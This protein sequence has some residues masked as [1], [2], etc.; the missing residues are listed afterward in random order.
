MRGGVSSAD[1]RK[2][3]GPPKNCLCAVAW[4]SKHGLRAVLSRQ[5]RGRRQ[6]VC[7]PGARGEGS[8]VAAPTSPE[9]C[10]GSAGAEGHPRR[11]VQCTGLAEDTRAPA[12]QSCA[13]SFKT[14]RSRAA[15]QGSRSSPRHTS[16]PSPRVQGDSS[17]QASS[18]AAPVPLIYAR[19]AADQVSAGTSLDA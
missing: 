17:A 10:Q 9:Q 8:V 19:V 1:P 2:P 11:C 5:A 3:R 4:S 18:E 7:R 13:S 12:S 15:P 16:G 6:G 14:A